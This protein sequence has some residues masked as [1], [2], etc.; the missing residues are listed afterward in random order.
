[1]SANEVWTFSIFLHHNDDDKLFCVWRETSNSHPSVMEPRSWKR[2]VGHAGKV[3]AEKDFDIEGDTENI[4]RKSSPQRR[5][6]DQDVYKCMVGSPIGS[7]NV[8]TV[9]RMLIW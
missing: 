6:Y 8:L 4:T 2:G 3:F 9:R 7:V 5:D 1:M